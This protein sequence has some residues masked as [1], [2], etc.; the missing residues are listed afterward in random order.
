MLTTYIVRRLLLFIPTILI[1]TIIIFLL[2]WIV[3]GDT[4]HAHPHGKRPE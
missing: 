1:V 4:A 2:M 3:P